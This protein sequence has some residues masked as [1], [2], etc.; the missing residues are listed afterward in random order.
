MPYTKNELIVSLQNKAK[1]L[2]RTPTCRDIEDD[3][4]M[5]SLYPYYII[6]GSI[7]NALKQAG[8]MPNRVGMHKKYTDPELLDI[9]RSKARS[10]GRT[11]TSEDMDADQ[12][13][14]SGMTYRYRFGSFRQ[15]IRKA[16]L[17]STIRHYVQHSN[18]ELLNML[19]EKAKT[20]GRSPIPREIDIDPNMPSSMAFRRHFGSI[21]NAIKEAGLLQSESKACLRYTKEDLLNMLKAKAKELGRV[22]TQ[23]ELNS[24]HDV[25]SFMTYV[26]R[27]GSFRSACKE[28]G[29]SYSIGNMADH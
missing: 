3:A 28:A 8:M 6:F 19:R 23:D 1:E 14:P 2:G 16:G 17:E 12:S 27:F 15:A 29:L 24:D 25:P 10:L 20:L 22:P 18:E 4:Q 9:L 5:P 13:L 11:P 21:R 26:S 7:P